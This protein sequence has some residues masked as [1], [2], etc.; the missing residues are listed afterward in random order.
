MSFVHF[1]ILKAENPKVKAG[2][3]SKLAQQFAGLRLMQNPT[4]SGHLRNLSFITPNMSLMQEVKT[5]NHQSHCFI[6]GLKG[7]KH[8]Q[9]QNHSSLVFLCEN[10]SKCIT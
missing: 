3:K 6:H 5:A 2:Y 1:S 9:Q 8:V 10:C 7:F 4:N